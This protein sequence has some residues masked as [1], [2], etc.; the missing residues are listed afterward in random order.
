L[1]ALLI[2]TLLGLDDC[3]HSYLP[4]LKPLS[5][6]NSMA[7]DGEVAPWLQSLSV[8][9]H[10]FSRSSSRRDGRR[11]DRG[12]SLNFRDEVLAVGYHKI[13]ALQGMKVP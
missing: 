1:D 13:Q 2:V 4:L 10:P 3:S 5:R 7:Q 9:S 6:C 8:S 11:Y 12:L